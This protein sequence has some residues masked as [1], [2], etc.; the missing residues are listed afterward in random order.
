MSESL[1]EL[2]L[3][4]LC[5]AVAARISSGADPGE[6]TAELTRRLRRIEQMQEKDRPQPRSGPENEET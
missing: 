3:K 4:E 6:L 5:E 2:L 1:Q